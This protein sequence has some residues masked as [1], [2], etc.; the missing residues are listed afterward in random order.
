V[1]SGP[2]KPGCPVLFRVSRVGSGKYHASRAY[3]RAGK[4]LITEIRCAAHFTVPPKTKTRASLP[5]PW[6]SHRDDVI[7]YG[8]SWQVGAVNRQPSEAIDRS[9]NV[10]NNVMTTSG[11]IIRQDKP[12]TALSARLRTVVSA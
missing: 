1:F 10:K 8:S 5:G 4:R 2:P 12:N 7:V 3:E 9:S 6:L 11:A